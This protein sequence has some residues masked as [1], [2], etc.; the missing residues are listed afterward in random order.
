MAMAKHREA[1]LSVG[2]ATRSTEKM[3][4]VHIERDMLALM[5]AQR[6]SSRRSVGFASELGDDCAITDDSRQPGTATLRA[7][8][9]AF[10]SDRPRRSLG[11][12]WRL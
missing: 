7:S 11:G 1:L 3:H 6:R 8:A 2:F 12:S 5:E 10:S 4:L 9:A